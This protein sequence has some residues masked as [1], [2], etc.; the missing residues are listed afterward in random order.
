MKLDAAL[1]GV[2]RLGIDTAPLI[3]LIEAHPR[4]DAIVLAVLKY[5]ADG[6]MSGITSVITLGEVLVQ[7]L[8]HGDH[9]LQ[10]RYRD[11][12]LHSAGF[13]LC[14]ID[15]GSAKRAAELRAVRH[16]VDGCAPGRR[17]VG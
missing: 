7:P 11:L 8:L 15:A 4:Y 9:A 3:Y 6:R 13:R 5:I 16:A 17:S 14:A 10:Q 1:R 2:T 12:L